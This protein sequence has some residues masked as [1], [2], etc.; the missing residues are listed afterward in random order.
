MLF[1]VCPSNREGKITMSNKMRIVTNE[2]FQLLLG[3][4]RATEFVCERRKL[5]DKMIEKIKN[6]LGRAYRTAKK[7]ASVIDEIA[8]KA[9][10]RGFCFAG[11]FKLAELTDASIR[12]VDN[13]ISKLKASGEVIVM[14]RENPNS[15][16]AKTPIFIFKYHPNFKAI[17]DLLNLNCKEDCKEVCEEEISSISSETSVTDTKK[18]STILLPNLKQEKNIISGGINKLDKIVKILALKV[19][20]AQKKSGKE[21]THLS[22]YADKMIKNIVLDEEL[23]IKN[24]ERAKREANEPKLDPTQYP[25]FHWLAN[26]DK[27]NELPSTKVSKE[28]TFDWLNNSPVQVESKPKSS[29]V[30]IEDDFYGDDWTSEL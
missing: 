14:F 2:K 28:S 13:A 11:R 12:T 17:S 25:S 19:I 26:N 4:K 20:D 22:S 18:V 6:V 30:E 10:D 8:Y 27:S 29:E 3:L 15:N 23:R 24:A 1:F 5:K 9:S 21:V 16:S 7:V